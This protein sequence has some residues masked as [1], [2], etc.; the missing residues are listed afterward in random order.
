MGKG[1]KGLGEGSRSSSS[2]TH[3]VLARCVSPPSAK[4]SR[5][6]PEESHME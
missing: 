3:I 4:R 5:G 2:A 6:K 1:S